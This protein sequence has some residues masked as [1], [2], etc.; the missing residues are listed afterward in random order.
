MLLSVTPPIVLELL[1]STYPWCI[2]IGHPKLQIP[3]ATCFEVLHAWRSSKF[4]WSTI[5]LTPQIG[6]QCFGYLST[7][8][9]MSKQLAKEPCLVLQ[10]FIRYLAD[11]GINSSP[12]IF[13]TK[14]FVQVSTDISNNL[15]LICLGEPVA[16]A[17]SWVLRNPIVIQSTPLIKDALVPGLL[18]F[19]EG[20]LSF[21]EGLQSIQSQTQLYC[22]CIIM[23]V[24]LRQNQL[25]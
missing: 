25:E 7:S 5:D 2:L 4:C 24:L 22:L 8:L 3:A 6:I 19:I 20:V 13:L 12:R 18:S 17:E 9:T 16:A 15:F 10:K 23:Q 21:I 1:V 11:L 14:V